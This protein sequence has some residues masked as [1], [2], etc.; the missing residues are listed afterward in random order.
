[1]IPTIDR[2]TMLVS[3]T[4][5]LTRKHAKVRATGCDCLFHSF[6]Q[7]VLDVACN[8]LKVIVILS[9]RYMHVVPCYIPCSFLP[10]ELSLDRMQN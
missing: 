1:M 5:A 3:S 4:Y 6:A 2:Q 7:I 8:F 9:R 10:P